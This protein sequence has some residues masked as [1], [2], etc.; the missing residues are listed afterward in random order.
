MV[1]RACVQQSLFECA[2]M[3]LTA[4]ETQGLQYQGPRRPDEV[5]TV[6]MEA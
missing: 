1:V 3:L 6:G 4:A 2:E 5:V